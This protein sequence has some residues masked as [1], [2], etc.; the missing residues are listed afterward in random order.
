MISSIFVLPTSSVTDLEANW[1]VQ[2]FLGNGNTETWF[3]YVNN[4]AVAKLTLPDDSYNGDILNV[5]G[6]VT[7]AGIAPVAAATRLSWCCRTRFPSAADR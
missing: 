6:T 3:V 7:F 5:T 2:D 4:I 1:L